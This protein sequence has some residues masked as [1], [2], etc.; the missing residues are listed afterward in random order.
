M[1]H[2]PER[3]DAHEGR[4]MDDAHGGKRTDVDGASG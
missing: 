4:G 3:S 1:R 2:A